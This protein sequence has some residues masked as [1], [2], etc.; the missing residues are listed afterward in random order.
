MTKCTR[1]DL[2]TKKLNSL[3]KKSNIMYFLSITLFLCFLHKFMCIFLESPQTYVFYTILRPILSKNI[4]D[5]IRGLLSFFRKK[6]PILCRI[7]FG[8]S[9]LTTIQSYILQSWIS[10]KSKFD[11]PY[12]TIGWSDFGIFILL[13]QKWILVGNLRLK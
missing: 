5:P 7:Y 10:K 4:F 6:S 2:F 3:P 8:L 11:P 1:Q 12:C 9:I 13:T